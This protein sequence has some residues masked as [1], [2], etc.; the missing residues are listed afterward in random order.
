ML[1]NQKALL[2][3]TIQIAKLLLS[4]EGAETG[5]AIQL[6]SHKGQVTKNTLFEDSPHSENHLYKM[7]IYGQQMPQNKI[8]LLN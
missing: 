7:D 8:R 1:G 5:S 3:F 2:P 4:N 6:T